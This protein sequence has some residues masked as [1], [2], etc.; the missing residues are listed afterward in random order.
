MGGDRRSAKQFVMEAKSLSLAGRALLV[1][2]AALERPELA[3]GL[4]WWEALVKAGLVVT[5]REV[6]ARLSVGPDRLWTGSPCWESSS[7]ADWV[8]YT[9]SNPLQHEPF[10]IRQVHPPSGLSW[11]GRA[12]P[13]CTQAC[14]HQIPWGAMQRLLSLWFWMEDPTA[15]L[16]WCTPRSTTAL[17]LQG[18]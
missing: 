17:K 9:V 8:V 10:V 12:S 14:V 6:G 18:K 3:V 7:N 15:K 5:A 11:W 16:T 2:G 13:W 1:Q 4:R